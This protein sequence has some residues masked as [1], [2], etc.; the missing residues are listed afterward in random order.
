MQ[1]LLS[2]IIAVAILYSIFQMKSRDIEQQYLKKKS[3]DTLQSEENLALKNEQRDRQQDEQKAEITGNFIEKTLSKLL[4]NVLKTEEGRLFFENIIKP[5]N[6]P[7]ANGKYSI[8]INNNNLIK[9]M[10]HINSFGQDT[11]ERALCGHIVTIHYQIMN[12]ENNIVDEQTKTFTLGSRSILPGLDSVIVGMSIGQTRQAILPAKYAYIETR[13]HRDGIDSSAP[14]KI[15]VTLQ[16][17]LP[18]NFIKDDE[19]KIFDDEL[20]Y[21]MPLMCGERASFDAV[22]TQITDGKVLFDSSKN[23]QR[24]SM[25]IGDLNYPLIFSYAL[26]NKVAVGSRIVLAKGKTFRGL[27]F[28]LSKIFP[29]TQ[30]NPQEYFM[31]ELKNFVD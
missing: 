20:S 3:A 15:N 23:G 18:K 21:K 28:G 22:I 27:G 29:K 9:G 19:V 16:Q 11:D 7:L 31:L 4:I 2:L 30:L 5:V 14:Y 8:K 1:K 10:F 6:Q 12:L 24:I 17:I 13:Y 25:N 26:H